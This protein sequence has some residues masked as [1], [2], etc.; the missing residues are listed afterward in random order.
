MHVGW[1]DLPLD[2]GLA[3]IQAI[4]LILNRRWFFA[5]TPLWPPVDRAVRPNH[6]TTGHGLLER[7]GGND[8]LMHLIGRCLIDQDRWKH[9]AG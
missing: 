6:W 7:R 4:S 5:A 1:T 3:S 8:L 2:D 9:G